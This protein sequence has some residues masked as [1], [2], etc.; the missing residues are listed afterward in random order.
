MN[1]TSNDMKEKIKEILE[2]T[3]AYNVENDKVAQDLF[4]LFGVIKSDC[5]YYQPNK[6]VTG[7]PCNYCGMPERNHNQSAL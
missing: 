1:K 3:F 2:Q 5:D 6:D 7:M 4:D